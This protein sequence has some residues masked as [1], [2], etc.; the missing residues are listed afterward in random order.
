MPL[1]RSFMFRPLGRSRAI[2]VIGLFLCASVTVGFAQTFSALRGFSGTDGGNSISP[3]VQG[4][5]GEL[6]GTTQSDGKNSAGTVFKVTTAGTLKTLHNFCSKASCADG[7]NPTAGLTLGTDG[8]FYGVAFGGGSTTCGA[9]GCGTIFK[10]TSDGTLTTLYSFCSQSGCADGANPYGGLVQGTD[11]SLYGT[12]ST[13]GMSSAG[14][15][16]R[17]TTEG[18]FTTLHT[19]DFTDG[20]SPFGTLIQATNGNFYGTTSAGGSG[21]DGTVFKITSAGSL[22]TLHNFSGKDGFAPYAGL[23]QSLPGVAVGTRQGLWGTTTSGG[24]HGD[25]TIFVITLSGKFTKIYDFCAAKSC[26]DGSTPFA[27]VLMDNTSGLWILT[28]SGGSADLGLLLRSTDD[29]FT[30]TL[31]HNFCATPAC[32][33]GLAPQ[34]T[35]VQHT[36]GLLYG[37]TP[38]GDLGFGAIYSIS[39]GRPA[40]VQ[41]LPNSAK[42]G[43]TIGILGTNLSGVTKVKFGSLSAKFKMV[44]STFITATV[45]AGATSAFVTVTTSSKTLRSNQTFMVVP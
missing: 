24:A 35:L 40:F 16:F 2:R 29:G 41:A 4:R 14:T 42:A 8:N 10:I 25:G 36:N 43:A 18:S 26:A 45:P 22:S 38:N 3:L 27:G 12:T 19:F 44:S 17:V 5:D 28:A 31:V 30:Y 20:A 34:A 37:V 32:A 11:G 6:Y 23:F 1:I 9:S 15:V 21:G 13:F 7:S 33:D 39:S